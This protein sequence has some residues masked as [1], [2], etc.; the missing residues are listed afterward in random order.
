MRAAYWTG[1]G[2]MLI[3]IGVILIVEFPQL[4]QI[5]FWLMVG[6][7]VSLVAGWGYTIRDERQRQQDRRTEEIQRRR[8]DKKREQS[9]HLDRIIQYELLERLGVPEKSVAIKYQRW[10]RKQ[11]L[12]AR[13]REEVGEDADM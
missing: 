8:Q 11:K 2:V 4:S 9:H 13:F 10:L 12:E 3:P 7:L 6:G 5:G 1:I